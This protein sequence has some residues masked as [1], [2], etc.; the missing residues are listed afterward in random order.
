MSDSKAVRELFVPASAIVTYRG[1]DDIERRAN[2]DA[3]L[4]WLAGMPRIEVIVVEQDASPRLAGPL[5]HPAA[6]VVPAFNPGPFNESWGLNV[7]AQHASGD[8]LLFG[9][10]DVLVPS[11]LEA[12]VQHC[13]LGAHVAKPHDTLV[14]LSPGETAEARAGRLPQLDAVAG[15]ARD[16]VTERLA[17]CC[18]WFAM[19]RDACA[20][21][22]TFD[23]RFAGRGDA[24][25]AMTLKIE[26][27]RL[28]TWQIGEGPALRLWHP[29]A[30]ECAADGRDG[31]PGLALDAEYARYDEPALARVFAIQR[32]LGGRRDKYAPAIR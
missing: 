17:L 31:A 20:A 12:A 29:D 23:E 6:R 18:G 8:V 30:L 2:L 16:A 19:R 3:V 14:D 21:V 28:S 4:R 7:G 10:A 9:D 22:G 5:A 15:R 32:Q 11:G 26:L 1:A 13:E 27:A 24:D 25:R